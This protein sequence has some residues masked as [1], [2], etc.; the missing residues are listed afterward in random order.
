MSASL[1]RVAARG[2][3]TTFFRANTLRTAQPL[4]A[5]AAMI[6][7]GVIAAP[8]FSTSARLR[9]DHGE[10]T[11]EEF[12]ARYEAS[13]LQPESSRHGLISPPPTHPLAPFVASKTTSMGSTTSLW[14]SIG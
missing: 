8:T 5:R 3:A 6:L 4:S 1:L 13:N 9:S 11:F 14:N 2:P 12:S 10:E 7:P